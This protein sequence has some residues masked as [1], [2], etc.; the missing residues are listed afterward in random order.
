M[1]SIVSGLPT[2]LRLL[3]FIAIT[4]CSI[5]LLA[6]DIEIVTIEAEGR[7]D[8]RQQAVN[9]ALREAVAKVNGVSVKS[10]SRSVSGTKNVSVNTQS[11]SVS[12][13]AA[14]VDTQG[15]ARARVNRYKEGEAHGAADVTDVGVATST[16]SQ[17]V[18]VGAS[19]SQV[20]QK[21]SYN[22]NLQD[23]SVKSSGQIKSY[24][25]VDVKQV[26]G[27][28][29]AHVSASIAKFKQSVESKRIRLAVVPFR[30]KVP[31]NQAKD[32]ERQFSQSIVDQLSQSRKFA[33]LDRDFIAEQGVELAQLQAGEVPIDEMAKLGNRL[34]ADF[35]VV[36]TIDQVVSRQR[37]QVMKSTGR[38]IQMVDQG[39]RLSFRLIEAAT[40]QIKFAD[41]LDNV[42]TSQGARKSISIM[43]AD[44]GRA[45][46]QN[47]LMDFYPIRV[48]AVQ[49]DSIVLGQGGDTVERGQRFTLIQYGKEIFDSYTQESLGRLENKVGTVEVI[50]VQSKQSYARIVNSSVDLSEVFEAGGFVVRPLPTKSKVASKAVQ[51]KKVKAAATERIKKLEAESEDDW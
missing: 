36:G 42:A 27:V 34:T 13:A 50:D 51:T 41:S 31:T 18:A 28:F 32:F 12:V 8:S 25:V 23:I 47:I 2:T 45:V 43:G 19:S 39:A 15:V 24:D 48:E 44:A 35:L 38:E 22:A 29:I 33:V 7:G 4:C 30:V 37:V 40:G 20:D 6:A 14:R 16:R 9:D 1:T 49:N 11:Q 21:T 17:A 46:A 26:D 3:T 5:S 10:N